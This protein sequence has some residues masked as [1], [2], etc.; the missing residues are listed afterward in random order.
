M[1]SRL[2]LIVGVCLCVSLAHVVSFA[3]PSLIAL[4]YPSLL[5]VAGAWTGGN[6]WGVALYD[7]TSRLFTTK[8]ATFEQGYTQSF[9]MDAPGLLS[10]APTALFPLS[11]DWDGDGRFEVGLYNQTDGTF[12]L[13][14]RLEDSTVRIVPAF[15]T[16][17]TFT[18]P[19]AGDW[20]GDGKFGIGYY[21]TQVRRFTLIN[22]VTNAAETPTILNNFSTAEA[23]WYPVT[24]DISGSG[25]WTVGLYSPMH[26][27][28]YFADG[29]ELLTLPFGGSNSSR[30]PIL[31]EWDHD[32]MGQPKPGSSLK[33]NQTNLG[34]FDA[35]TQTFDLWQLDDPIPEDRNF[36]FGSNLLNYL[37]IAGDWDNDGIWSVGLYQP[38]QNKV[39]L[40]NAQID[41]P[42]VSQVV[43]FSG[44]G[45]SG[46]PI[47][48]NWVRGKRSFPGLFEPFVTFY[49]S[50]GDPFVLNQYITA[51]CGFPTT[52]PHPVAGDWNGDGVDSIGFFTS[53]ET[54]SD[55]V[56]CNRLTVQLADVQFAFG[57]L[58]NNWLPIAGDWNADGRDSIGLYEPLLARFHLSDEINPARETY[59]FVFGEADK[60]W[61]PIAGDWLGLGYTDVGVYD[62][63][64]S[65]FHLRIFRPRQFIN[66]RFTFPAPARNPN[67]RYFGYYNVDGQDY[68]AIPATNEI[69]E[70]FGLG[71]NNIA[72]MFPRFDSIIG[73]SIGVGDYSMLQSLRD[74]EARRM[75]M[76]INASAIFIDFDDVRNQAITRPDWRERLAYYADFLAPHLGAIETFYFDEPLEL[77]ITPNDFR[78]FTQALQQTF[79]SRRVMVI[80]S[81]QQIINNNLTDFYLE[82]V[83]DLGVDWYYTDP[84]YR[85]NQGMVRAALGEMVTRYP[86]KRLWLAVDGITRFGSTSQDLIDAFEMYYSQALANPRIVGML[87]F[88]YPG[89]PTQFPVAIKQLFSPAETVYSPQLRALQ[90]RAG[91]EV[92][93]KQT[94][95]PIQ[96]VGVFDPI[97]GQWSFLYNHISKDPDRIQMFNPTGATKPIPGDWNGDGIDTPGVY[98]DARGAF[99]YTN[100]T[101]V[102]PFPNGELVFGSPGDI[103]LAGRWDFRMTKDGVGVYRPT[104]GI[105]YLKRELTSGVD[106]YYMVLGNPGDYAVTGDW[107]GD[108]YDSVGVYRPPITNWYQADYNGRGIVYSD[109]DFIWPVTGLPIAGDWDGDKI[110]TVGAYDPSNGVF[111][112]HATNADSGTNLFVGFFQPGINQIPV[113]GHWGGGLPQSP[114]NPRLQGLIVPNGTINSESR[115]AD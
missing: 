108:G 38:G 101:G 50:L 74:A 37:P 10:A 88:K 21:D 20:D 36:L 19:I 40:T 75:R 91:K 97:T 80:E 56:L 39:Y 114:P 54:R 100:E 28:F 3:K 71:N 113:I 59:T 7:Q 68:Y 115:G 85:A 66:N 33:Y 65:R 53:D 86:G 104:N 16:R 27:L 11:G 89:D 34:L 103:P 8:H 13:L 47:A 26:G 87:V 51:N 29:G 22:D 4:P 44:A 30:I 109:N 43:D 45:P 96:T 107:D 112:L 24:A 110:S 98:D 63:V 17:S 69:A 15:G 5:P 62:P 79:P 46:L 67:L 55:F 95:Q 14:N 99:I 111:M 105:L 58:D 42:P 106:D 12:T 92:I 52:N 77:K 61:L 41:N 84:V 76:V 18:Y 70:S 35:A 1:I 32:Q 2:T 31:G 6:R 94:R 82:Y 83:D 57:I 73:V 78:A 81:A 23:G 64:N 48:G 49:L 102:T 72:H 60:G 90:I 93:T 9:G 25:R